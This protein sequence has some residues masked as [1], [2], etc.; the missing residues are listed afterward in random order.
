MHK[1]VLLNQCIEALNIDPNGIY[2]DA[3]FGRGGHSQAILKQLSPQGR[4]IVFD[5]DPQAIAAAHALQDPRLSIH[6]GSFNQL[7]SV[8]AEL[9]VL[10]DIAGILMDL[11]VSSPQL[12]QAER[13]FSFMHEG[14]LDMRMDPSQEPSAADWIN[15]AEEQDIARVLRD[16]GEERFAKRIARHIV[17]VREQA[18]IHTTTKLA[19]IISEAVPKYDQHKHPATRSFQAIRIFINHELSDLQQTLLQ[20]IAALK[21]GGRLAVISFHSLEDRIVKHFIN[22]QVKGEEVPIHIPMRGEN[23]GVTLKK[24]G[25][26]IVANEQEIADNPRARSARLRV[27]EKI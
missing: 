12:D 21:K 20:V 17:Q 19:H 8:L 25:K 15:S 16:Y 18:P 11:G 1:P 3:T 23:P 5:K 10:G 4:L 2:V 7:Q 6:Q 26:P 9:N 13:G 27:A 24:V 22:D 14:P